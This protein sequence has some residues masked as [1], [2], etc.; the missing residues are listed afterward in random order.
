MNDTI[1]IINLSNDKSVG[2]YRYLT[3]ADR[4]SIALMKN[5]GKK[6]SEIA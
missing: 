1:Q 4:I 5:Q 2:K 6:Q 3:Y